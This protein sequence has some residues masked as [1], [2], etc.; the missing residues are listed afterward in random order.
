M[1]SIANAA[2][3][4]ENVKSTT[5]WYTHY[6]LCSSFFLISDVSE[7]ISAFAVIVIVIAFF[8]FF[9]FYS[10]VSLSMYITGYYS[11]AAVLLV[12]VPL[13]TL[14]IVQRRG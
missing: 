6:N 9:L 7:D 5:Y 1:K 10:N 3:G 4:D 12:F 11:G 2:N 8:S 14:P 13:Y